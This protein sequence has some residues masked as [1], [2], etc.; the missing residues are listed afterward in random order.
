MYNARPGLL[1]GFHGCDKVRQKELLI[2]SAAMPVS[3]QPYDWLGNGMYFWENNSER[4]LDWAK[5]KEAKGKIKE[6]AVIGAVIDLGHC[7]DLLDTS[8]I[9]MITVYFNLM[10]FELEKVGKTLP[11][12]ED[13]KTDGNHDKLLRYLDCATLEFM[14]GQI[15]SQYKKDITAKNHSALKMFDS[16]RGVFPEGGAAYTGSGFYAKSHI[17]ICIRNPN[18]IKGYFLKR[19]ELDFLLQETSR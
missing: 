10:K 7:C 8:F 9:K 19:D 13:I 4:A 11:E 6:A 15:R 17:Q 5:D 16:V 14:H 18:C 2:N 12:N 3:I 1:I